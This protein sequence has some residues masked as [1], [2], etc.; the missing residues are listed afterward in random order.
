[1]IRLILSREMHWKP[2]S[3]IDSVGALSEA[4]RLAQQPAKGKLSSVITCNNDRIR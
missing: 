4:K 3:E 2:L 1:M